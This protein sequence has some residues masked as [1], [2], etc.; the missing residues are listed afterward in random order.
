[1]DDPYAI[2]RMHEDG[3]SK[4]MRV[5]THAIQA[6]VLVQLRTTH[7]WIDICEALTAFQVADDP[8]EIF[9]QLLRLAN[10]QGR[11]LPHHRVM[12]LIGDYCYCSDTCGCICSGSLV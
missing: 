6:P 8:E 4:I 10:D 2:D 5:S 1:M 3:L 11:A 7:G 9:G 12:L